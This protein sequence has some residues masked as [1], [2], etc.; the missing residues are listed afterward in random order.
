MCIDPLF[1]VVEIFCLMVSNNIYIRCVLLSL[2]V[3]SSIECQ[4]QH[5]K[6]HK[7]TCTNIKERY[8]VWKD[9]KSKVL[10]DGTP[11]DTKEG[12]CAI[13]LE[14][15]ITNPVVLPCG[16]AFCFSCV[17]HYQKSNSKDDASCPY[18]RGEIP[19][20]WMRAAERAQSYSQRAVASSKGSED[21][22][23]YANLALAEY[24]AVIEL[25]NPD[26]DK[27]MFL[28][29]FMAKTLMISMADQPEEA[30]KVAKEIL[31]HSE[32]YPGILN[33]ERVADMKYLQAESY[34]DCGKWKDAV[35]IFKSLIR[36]Y[37]QRGE[38][39]KDL[40][41]MGY[42]RAL[43]ELQKYDEAIIFGNMGIKMVR[44]RPGVHKYV[45]LSQKALG[46]I[47][48]AKKTVSRAILYEDHWD[49]VIMQENKQY[50]QA[51]SYSDCGKWKDAVKIF[52]SLIREYKQ[53]GE[54]PKD[55][56]L[57]GYSRALYELQKYDEAIIFGNMGIKMVRARPGVHKYV[58]LSQ[59]ALGNIDEAKK[60][61]SRAILYED[62]W[63]KVIMQENKQL[64]RELNNL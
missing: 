14:E 33:F 11:L 24:D 55:L 52:K 38:D 37:K 23:K 9:Y 39:P 63:D 60:T 18:C 6:K 54:D 62:H 7:P 56:I 30:I 45:V 32:K 5:W 15:T 64:L 41:L 50:L 59:K 35:K 4:V 10:P 19:N 53:R 25:L 29:V 34:S 48:E 27:V 31:L 17:G 28:N 42:S 40:I 20:M 36:E 58:V 47:D 43:Y 12:P 13:C 26:E 21:Q 49:K 8:N 16:H 22:K 44:A 1:C 51:E 3:I 46:N 57:M 2:Y 61:V